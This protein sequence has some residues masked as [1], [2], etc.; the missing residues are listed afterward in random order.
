MSKLTPTKVAVLAA[1]VCISLQATTY[2]TNFS[3]IFE[4]GSGT[5]RLATY[6]NAAGET[7]FALSLTPQFEEQK[8]V[9]YTHLTL[10]T[11]A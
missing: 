3:S 10:P 2:A 5:S 11:K 4:F 7:S 1:I 6:K 8:P 9:S